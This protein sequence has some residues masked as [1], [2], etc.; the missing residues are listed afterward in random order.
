M[1]DKR[2][3]GCLIKS[4]DESVEH[5][6]TYIVTEEAITHEDQRMSRMNLVDYCDHD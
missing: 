1:N 4:E 6:R 5:T 2:T 3:R